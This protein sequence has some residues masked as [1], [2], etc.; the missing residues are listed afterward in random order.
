MIDYKLLYKAVKYFGKNGFIQVEVPWRVSKEA[1][2]RTFDSNLAFKSG[3]KFLVGSAEQGLIELILNN[4]LNSSMIMSVS[5]CFRNE[6]EDYYHQQE[7]IKLELMYLSNSEITNDYVNFKIFRQIVLG[8]L[9]KELRINASDIVIKETDDNIS[10]YSE[11]ILINGIEYGSYGIRRINEKYYIYGTGIALPRA[12]KILAE[13]T[14]VKDI[15]VYKKIKKE[16]KKALNKTKGIK[17][18]K[19]NKKC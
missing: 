16:L 2:N 4:Q 14:K 5:P 12:S 3:D 17:W 1:I 8:F 13:V 10:L 7:F 6:K 15:S 18:K 9:T 11:D 19:H